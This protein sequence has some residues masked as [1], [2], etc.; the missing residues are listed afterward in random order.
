MANIDENFV[1]KTGLTV[2]PTTITTATGDIVTTGNVSIGNTVIDGTS[3]NITIGTTTIDGTTGAITTTGNITTTAGNFVIGTTVMAPTGEVNT[4]NIIATGGTIDGTSIGVG[5][6]APARFTTL[7]ATDTLTVNDILPHVSNVSNIGSATERFS[8]IFVNE[9][10]LST[11]T[12]YLGDTPILGTT[13]NVINIHADPGQSISMQTTGAAGALSFAANAAI[14]MQTTGNNADVIVQSNGTGSSTRILSG[15]A[16]LATAPTM[17]VTGNLSTVGNSTVT[18]NMQVDGNLTVGGVQATINA[19]Q[20]NVK[21]NIVVV[22]AGE[23]GMGVTAGSAGI[24]FARGQL[25]SYQLVF[26]ESDDQLHFGPIGGTNAMADKPWANSTFIAKNSTDTIGNLTVSGTLTAASV[27]PTILNTNNAQITGGAISATPISGSTGS[28]TTLTATSGITGTLQTAAQPNV[29][30]VGTLTSLAVTGNITANAFNGSGAG[31]TNVPYSAL[32]GSPAGNVTIGTT[33]ISLGGSSTTLAGL[34]SVSSTS[35]T[36]ELTGNVSGSAATVTAAAQPAI[37]SVGTLTSLT[38]SGDVTVGGN[39]TVNGTTT[40]INATNLAVTDL[41]ITVAKDA[42]TA[43]A[44]NGAGLTVAGPTTAATLTYASADDS[45]NSNKKFS[46]TSFSGPLT[47]NVTGNVSGSAATVTAAAQPAITSVGT[48]TSLSVSGNVAAANF[49]GN[50]TGSY[51]GITSLN[52]TNALG[53]TPYNATNPSGYTTNTGTVTGVT[54]T[55]PVVSSGGTAPVISMPAATASVNGYM[56][57]TYAAKLDGIAAGATNVTNTNQLTNGAGFL[58]ASGTIANATNAGNANTVDG[59]HVATGTN[60]VA[61]QIVRTDASGY[62][63]AGYINSGNGNEN[64]NS[65]PDRVWG[66]NGSDSYLRTYRTSALSV[67]YATSAG[68]VPWTGVTDKPTIPQIYRHTQGTA[69]T[70]WTIAHNFNNAAVPLVSCY[71][72]DGGVDTQI[73]PASVKVTNANTVTVTF[74]AATAGK[75]VILI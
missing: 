13:D 74:T 60:N 3:G 22:N 65:N 63:Q 53:Y 35:I 33:N 10:R 6:P 20:L 4:A 1:V 24:Q 7:E 67:N 69:S 40:T 14:T 45:W 31:L 12:L 57:S 32:T 8:T 19:D 43:V 26:N 5:T 55:S 66:S 38:T 50:H 56:T 36:G 46:A 27:Q 72:L 9:A 2:G 25:G 54:A 73:L 70:T 48:L 34:T 39:L 75:A 58:T 17:T 30:S 29:T 47:G 15:T 52:V 16:I 42:T 49:N 37:T 61:N 59:L 23:A 21:D 68:S 41:N 18:G 64:N 28:F 44:A 51:V 11:N 71:V 62:I